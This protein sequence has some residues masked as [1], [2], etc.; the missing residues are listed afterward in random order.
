MPYALFRRRQREGW[1]F[2]V[3]DSAAEDA[4]DG[5]VRLLTIDSDGTLGLV[6]GESA[7]RDGVRELV[8]VPGQG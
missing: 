7:T 5:T 3:R 4:A 6:S 8:H 1:R 2:S